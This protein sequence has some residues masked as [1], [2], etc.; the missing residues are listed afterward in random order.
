[1]CIRDRSKQT[2]A[3]LVDSRASTQLPQRFCGVAE[4]SGRAVPIEMVYS[5]DKREW[6]EHAAARFAKLCPNIQVK[7]RAME[8][9]SA[10][11]AMLDGELHPTI[12]APTDEL[13]LR[14]FQYQAERQK[15]ADGWQIIRRQELVRSPQVLLIWQDRLDV[16]S[17]VLREQPR[18][19]YKRQERAGRLHRN[20][21]RT[22]YPPHRLCIEERPAS[23]SAYTVR[24]VIHRRTVGEYFCCG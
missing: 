16:L 8:D 22:T 11:S 12:W 9:F 17:S 3:I 20:R 2:P 23:L 6:I 24:S 13:S 4:P 21:Q 1:M 18:Y 19:V 5:E 15:R 7:L 14:Y 10:L